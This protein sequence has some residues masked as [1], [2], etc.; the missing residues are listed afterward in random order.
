MCVDVD[1]PFTNKINSN[2]CN[3]IIQIVKGNFKAFNKVKSVFL[4]YV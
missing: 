3:S 4:N 1:I 2:T